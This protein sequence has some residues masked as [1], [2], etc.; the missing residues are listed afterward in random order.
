M[1]PPK[2]L[3]DT[4]LGGVGVNAPQG[5]GVDPLCFGAVAVT[6]NL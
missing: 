2:I 4:P 1:P 3:Q 5:L 6:Y